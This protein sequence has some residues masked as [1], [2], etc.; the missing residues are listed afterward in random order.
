MKK[1]E[2][3]LKGCEF[4]DK[5]FGYR[6]KE[7]RRKLEA[8]KDQCETVKIQAQIEYEES[9]NKLGEKDVNY[10]AVINDVINSIKSIKFYSNSLISYAFREY[11]L[12]HLTG[13][14]RSPLPIIL[15]VISESPTTFLRMFTAPFTSAF[16]NLPTDERNK[17]RFT[18][19]PKYM[20]CLPTGS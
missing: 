6:E 14:N 10:E 15:D 17:P 13:L 19:L 20:S 9:M 4:L 7:I 12:L 8:A 16:I 1:L 5:L 2:A 11:G 3:I 18:L